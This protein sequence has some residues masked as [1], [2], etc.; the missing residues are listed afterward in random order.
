MFKYKKLATSTIPQ[1]VRNEDAKFLGW[2]K[3]RSGEIFALYNVIARG[4]PSFGSTVTDK[5]LRKLNL[6]VPDAPIPDGPVR[7]F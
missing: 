2:Q 1:S 7:E 6:D 3:M 4:H 5:G